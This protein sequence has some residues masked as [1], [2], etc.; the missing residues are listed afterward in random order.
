MHK[1][2]MLLTK[3]SDRDEAVSN[4]ENFLEDYKNHV[5]DWYVIGGRWS[6]TLNAKATEFFKLA[7]AHL[8]KAYPE[9]GE[10]VSSKMVEEQSEVL[11]SIWSEE[12]G[13]SGL[14]PYK[15]DSYSNEGSDD[16]VLPLNECIDAINEWTKDMDAEA[17][18]MWEKMLEAKASGEKH[19]MSA[20][21][22]KRYAECKYDEFCFE[23]NVYD[24][25]EYT[26]DPKDALE[27]ADQYFAVMVDMH[28]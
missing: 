27:N 17:E 5:W 25:D 6:G 11:Q 2:V 24:I 18:K 15:R 3:A 14:N 10:F 28:N 22:A 13:A 12:L 19:D 16:D 26:N 21:Y 4:V 23:S 1:G 8:K 7:H 20:Y 9:S